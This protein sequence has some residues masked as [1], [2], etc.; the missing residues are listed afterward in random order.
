MTNN[1]IDC[2]F[3]VSEFRSWTKIALLIATLELNLLMNQSLEVGAFGWLRAQFQADRTSCRDRSKET[4]E[5]FNVEIHRSRRGSCWRAICF[6]LGVLGQ[7]PTRHAQSDRGAESAD[8]DAIHFSQ[9]YAGQ[10]HDVGGRDARVQVQLPADEG[11]SLV[12]RDPESRG[13]YLLHI[14]FKRQG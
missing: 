14:V 8:D 6:R 12:C 10:A 3:L 9:Q 13:G 7:R 5:T 1:R 4:C 2:S 11:R